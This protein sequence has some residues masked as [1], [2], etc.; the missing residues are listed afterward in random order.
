MNTESPGTDDSDTLGMLTVQEN[1]LGA[2]CLSALEMEAW[3]QLHLHEWVAS[4]RH[5]GKGRVFLKN[6]LVLSWESR[7]F[8][9]RHGEDTRTFQ[10]GLPV[11][12][13]AHYWW[14]AGTARGRMQ[15]SS[16]PGDPPKPSARKT[17]P[18]GEHSFWY[19]ACAD[20]CT[21]VDSMMA[22]EVGS[23]LMIHVK[24]SNMW[25]NSCLV[26]GT[27]PILQES[28]LSHRGFHQTNQNSESP[29]THARD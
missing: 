1:H 22:P 12:Q 29:A 20:V 2:C 4:S 18:F 27:S 14:P 8:V 26:P 3:K 9:I 10:R 28:K 21:Q 24:F 25:L 7:P 16:F 17:R 23:C 15:S 13:S 5:S 19:S 11:C 6:R